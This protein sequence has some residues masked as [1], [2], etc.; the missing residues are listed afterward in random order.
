M[1]VA[2]RFVVDK[3]DVEALF[4]VVWPVTFSVAEVVVPAFRVFIVA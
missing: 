4:R 3:L 2:Y 1:P